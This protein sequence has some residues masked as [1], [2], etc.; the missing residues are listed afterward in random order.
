MSDPR[1]TQAVAAEAPKPWGLLAEFDTAGQLYHAAEAVRDAGYKKWDCYS[2]FPVHGLDD[3]MGLKDTKL[4]WLVFIGGAVGAISALALQGWMNGIDYQ[5]VVSG[6]PLFSIPQQIPIFFELT[7]LFASL[8]AFGSMFA[9]NDLPR[10]YHPA[11]TSERFRRVTDDKFFIGIEADDLYFDAEQTEELLR[12]AG[13]M[14]IE[15]LE[16]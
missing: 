8:T 7:V 1:D 16:D 15:W 9:F 2:P 11:F 12:K 14:H 3:A 4:P 6:K 10:F 5:Y 13:S